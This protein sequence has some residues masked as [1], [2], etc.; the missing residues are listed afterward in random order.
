MD[1]M[2]TLRTQEIHRGKVAHRDRLDEVKSEASGG[3]GVARQP[4]DASLSSPPLWS[5]KCSEERL[6]ALMGQNLI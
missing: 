4:A 6:L 2:I 5:V 3:V 1:G